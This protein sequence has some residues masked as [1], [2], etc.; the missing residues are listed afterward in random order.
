MTR[1]NWTSWLRERL[2]LLP[3]EPTATLLTNDLTLEK[4]T[5]TSWKQ[6][7]VN[8]AAGIVVTCLRVSMSSFC[9]NAFKRYYL[10]SEM[11]ITHDPILASCQPQATPTGPSI[12]QSEDPPPHRSQQ[13]HHQ[14]NNRLL[15]LKKSWRWC[16]SVN[17]ALQ[18]M[19][20]LD[21]I[22]SFILPLA[23]PTGHTQHCS[24]V[25]VKLNHQDAADAQFSSA[26]NLLLK[27]PK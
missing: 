2:I 20:P 24:S 7:H 16:L 3:S 19:N 23:P 18:R 6:K 5:N 13:W 15:P 11:I 4:S 17:P 22:K 12:T 9:V 1:L 25:K 21:L 27:F 26:L 8:V 14:V 10:L